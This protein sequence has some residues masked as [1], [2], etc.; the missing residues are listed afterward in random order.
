[1]RQDDVH[2]HQDHEGLQDHKQNNNNNID[3]TDNDISIE[4]ELP[5]ETYVTIHD[6]N[7][8]GE[9]NNSQMNID[10][11]TGEERGN[12]AINNTHQ[13]HLRPR[14]TTRNCKYALAQF[15]NKLIMP[16]PHAHHDD[17]NEH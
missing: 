1:V 13:Y 3:I 8:V 10:P 9:M 6:I 12:E 7:I 2:Q 14:P 4:G 11:E 15:N 16:K 5:K 17:A